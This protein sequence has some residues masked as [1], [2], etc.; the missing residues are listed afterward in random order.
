[1]NPD[2][3]GKLHN[4]YCR[5]DWQMYRGDGPRGMGPNNDGCV[6]GMDPGPAPV[7]EPMYIDEAVLQPSA[8]TTPFDPKLWDI[9]PDGVTHI[10]GVQMVMFGRYLRQRCDWCGVILLEYDRER[11]ATV[12]LYP[13]DPAMWTPGALVRVDGHVSAEIDN[14]LRTDEGVQLPPDSCAFDPKTQVGVKTKKPKSA[15]VDEMPFS[16]WVD[17][18][19][20]VQPGPKDTNES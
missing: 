5:D 6:C 12:G 17:D 14:P 20:M 10:A 19:G 4:Q 13:V 9:E 16:T 11:V 8:Q 1:M 3:F 15:P 2:G 18:A 7:R